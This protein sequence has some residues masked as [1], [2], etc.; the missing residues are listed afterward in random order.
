MMQRGIWLSTITPSGFFT[1]ANFY[2]V[3]EYY[4]PSW[5]AKDLFFV[6]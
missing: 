1:A 6:S 2:P 4:E 5:L 3:F